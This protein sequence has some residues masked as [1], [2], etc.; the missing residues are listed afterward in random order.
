MKKRRRH[1]GLGEGARV[2]G[3]VW[4]HGT[5]EAASPLFQ[6]RWGGET[7]ARQH[8]CCR[9]V[10]SSSP[11]G[12]KLSLAIV[13]RSPWIPV[14]NAAVAGSSVARGRVPFPARK[15]TYP[16]ESASTFFSPL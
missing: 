13:F 9:I 14:I 8:R 3:G 4:K 1:E 6:S 16:D 15:G 10:W 12:S 5:G 2:W 11:T 7:S